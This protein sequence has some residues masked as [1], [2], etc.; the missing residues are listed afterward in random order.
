MHRLETMV[1]VGDFRIGTI[2]WGCFILGGWDYSDLTEKN[3]EKNYC[4]F[5]YI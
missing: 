4:I 2:E 5:T 3:M 1:D